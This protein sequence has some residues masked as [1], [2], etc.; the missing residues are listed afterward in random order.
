M[1]LLKNFSYSMTGLGASTLITFA[2]TMYAIR[3]IGP[4]EFGRYNVLISLSQAFIIPSLFGIHLASLRYLGA[5]QNKHKEII[6][7][8]FMTV[9]ISSFIFFPIINAFYPAFLRIVGGLD[10]PLFRLAMLFALV[11][12]FFFLFQSFFQGT[13]QFKRFSWLWVSSALCFVVPLCLFILIFHN[14]SFVVLFIS[15][16]IRL[17]VVI[18][19]GLWFFRNALFSFQKDVFRELIHYGSFEALSLVAGFFGL[20][21]IDNLMIQ[22]YLGS[23]AVGL[24]S[25]YLVA[26]SFLIG[27]VVSTFIQVFLP[28]ASASG[29]ISML[30]H[31]SLLLI[32]NYALPVMVGVFGLISVLFVIFG[33]NYAYDFRLGF[34]MA[35]SVTSFACFMLFSSMLQS[36][37]TKGARWMTLVAVVYAISNVSLNYLLIPRFELFGAVLATITATLVSMVLCVMILRRYFLLSSI[38]RLN[39]T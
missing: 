31:R 28:M 37:G 2:F 36:T 35:I 17:L 30:F 34:L 1:K 16:I 20:S 26:Y 38:V 19:A 29:D 33:K 4:S 11:E 32:R 3:Y 6:G 18:A 7:T 22:H 39:Q 25:A 21:M 24:Y 9:C 12:S 15:S 23:Q 13:G 10:V 8:A 27:K 14:H 5:W